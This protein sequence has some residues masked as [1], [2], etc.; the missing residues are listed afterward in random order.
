[1]TTTGRYD[2]CLSSEI[3]DESEASRANSRIADELQRQQRQILVNGRKV[4]YV[5]VGTGGPPILLLHGIG[6]SHRI[7]QATIP[8]IARMRR[9]VA[10]DLPGFGTSDSLPRLFG[11]VEAA[12]HIGRVCDA[13]DLV[14]V[15]LVG[16]SMGGMLAMQLVSSDPARVRRLALISASLTSIM[17]FYHHPVA[18]FIM[19]PRVCSR[20]IGQMLVAS[21]PIPR[22]LIE[23]SISTPQLRRFV[24]RDILAVPEAV[25]EQLLLDVLMSS[26]GGRTLSAALMGF[27][28]DFI[29][30]ASAVSERRLDTLVVAGAKDRFTVPADISAFAQLIGEHELVVVPDVGH[31]PMVERPRIVNCVLKEWLE[32]G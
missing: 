19:Q 32:I 17:K 1:M 10:I 22:I 16:H 21:M 2:K 12:D 24:C 25:D 8:S 3:S 31:W 7:W 28:F 18:G 26:G 11:A 20:F 9:V 4:N 30:A 6:A 13:L 29:R 23:V 5:D 14:Q 15:D 27:Q